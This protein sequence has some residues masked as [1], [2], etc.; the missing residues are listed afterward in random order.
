MGT[1]DTGNEAHFSSDF[2]TQEREAVSPS[3]QWARLGVGPQLGMPL[4]CRV[5]S[6]SCGN[7]F[8]PGIKISI[9]LSLSLTLPV[10]LVTRCKSASRPQ[11]VV[12]V[13][14]ASRCCRM[15]NNGGLPPAFLL[16]AHDVVVFVL[17]SMDLPKIKQNWNSS[18]I[19]MCRHIKRCCA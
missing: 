4:H 7:P 16:M 11:A 9:E 19:Q 18:C 1:R 15:D 8:H 2:A 12:V 10:T 14:T 17:L 5:Y 3:P 13:W 6:C